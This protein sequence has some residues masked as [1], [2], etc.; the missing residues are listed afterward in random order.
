MK[1]N[2]L[3]K[4]LAAF[5]I[6][7]GMT[8]CSKGPTDEDVI[9]LLVKNGSIWLY[10]SFDVKSNGTKPKV[11]NKK[12]FSYIVKFKCIA[13][14]GRMGY[15]SGC[16]EAQCCHDTEFICEVEILICK[17]EWDEWTDYDRRIIEKKEIGKYW[18]PASISLEEFYKDRLS[19]R[20]VDNSDKQ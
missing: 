13:P 20:A 3:I 10:F 4:I 2:L 1:K 5:F 19:N 16:P 9:N 12:I 14:G 11:N 7:V 6:V 17:N 8:G 15:V 18:R